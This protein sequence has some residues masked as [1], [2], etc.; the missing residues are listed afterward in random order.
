MLTCDVTKWNCCYF[1]LYYHFEQPSARR[2]HKNYSRDLT[3]HLPI[4]D[5][6]N[7]KYQDT[8]FLFEAE[9]KWEQGIVSWINCLLLLTT[10]SLYIYMK[11]L[12][13]ICYKQWWKYIT[14]LLKR[15]SNNIHYVNSN[16]V[17]YKKHL[18]TYIHGYIL[19]LKSTAFIYK[20][21]L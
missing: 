6:Q 5:I 17:K 2:H 11:T 12:L 1:K 19:I 7:A 4:V 21:K 14:K 18:R 3:Y 16:S 13:S 9:W 8:R 15:Y 20:E 10:S